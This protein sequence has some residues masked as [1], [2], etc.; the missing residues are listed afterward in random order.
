MYDENWFP[1]ADVA[2]RELAIWVAIPCAICA[3]VPAIFIESKSTL[4]RIMNL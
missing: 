3:I 4:M 1:S 2:V